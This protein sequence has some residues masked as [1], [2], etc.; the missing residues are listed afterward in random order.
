[1]HSG[2]ITGR[3]TT[4]AVIE[5]A[6]PGSAPATVRLFLS[7]PGVGFEDLPPG[8]PY[9]R[10]SCAAPDSGFVGNEGGAS[11][12]WY[13]IAYFAARG[14]S[15]ALDAFRTRR[16]VTSNT[17]GI[18]G[19][20]FGVRTAANLGL[21]GGATLQIFGT[22]FTATGDDGERFAGRMLAFDANGFSVVAFALALPSEAPGAFD[23]LET[24]V[25]SVRILEP[26]G[27]CSAEHVY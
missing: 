4:I 9:S 5:P 8:M 24:L 20:D 22:E 12:P 3:D 19:F 10:V 13:G 18:A 6:E 11:G 21:P 1:M 2:T 17:R 23:R 27:P 16:A 26:G 25:G 15:G 14:G 7:A